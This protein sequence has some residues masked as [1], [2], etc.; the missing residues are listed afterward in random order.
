MPHNDSLGTTDI[1]WNLNDLYDS[2]S[3]PALEQD[4]ARC[5]KNS[6]DLHK[7]FS[8][9]LADI[10]TSE[11]NT[12]VKE[13]EEVST[14]LG[15][16]ATFAFLQFTT[17]T[18]NP[19]AAAFLQHIQEV[20]S[21]V[22][23]ETVFFELEWNALSQEKANEFLQ[24]NDLDSYRH[25]L[26]SMR[27]YA[28]HLLSKPEETLLLEIAPVGKSSWTN[29]FDKVMGKLTFGDDNRTEEE[30]LS[31]LYDADRDTRRHAAMDLTEG[32]QSQL[33]ILTHVF[34]TVLAD[35]M[36]EDRLRSYDSW[37]SA[38][39]LHN[40][41]HDDTVEILVEEVTRR[42][43]IPTRYYQLK[44][45]LL[46][47]DELLDYDR[48]APLPDLP[49]SLLNWDKAKE[50]T[51]NAFSNFSPQM[52]E[53]AQLFF[54]KKWIHA[55][56]S[57]GKRGGAF[58]HPCVPDVH[59][60]VLVNYT[61]N[62]RDVSTVAHELG[63]GVH[64]HLAASQ[65]YF[66]SNTPLVVAETAS[67]FAE[68][69]VFN[70]QVQLIES[71]KAK[72]AF[73]CQKLESIFATVFRQVAMNR[74][75]DKIH[76]AR[77]DQ[78]ELTPDELAQYWL[79]TQ[80]AMFGDSVTLTEDYGIWWSYIPHFLNT[81]GYVYSYAFG[82]LLV[83]ALYKRYQEEGNDFV[84]K[85]IELLSAGGSKSPYDLVTPFGVDLN[86]PNFWAGGLEIIDLMLQS[87]EEDS[88]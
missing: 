59:P 53:I 21:R 16:I 65:G 43:D 28:S 63:H 18:D 20:A 8:G 9:R 27:R 79:E 5:E 46:G 83:L 4:I 26:E 14:T 87:V 42:Y 60:Y 48:Y 35:K 70:D 15:K 6:L 52:S 31:D 76:N 62:L 2:Q 54:D 66:N 33:H 85:Y 30:V 78:G 67:V 39:N 72:R 11:L 1:I 10:S 32:L 75:E 45:R 68:L 88:I 73:V 44:K 86:D 77:R 71:K 49:D 29:L 24:H 37:T 38:M 40:E 41:L 17:Q 56:I 12:L 57:E 69:L 55:P 50:I 22:G 34:N 64:Q 61:G 58:A 80:R 51:L 36:I 74:F 82:E 19:E 81:P 3:D 23:R 84:P 47:M 13:L 25:Y 7:K